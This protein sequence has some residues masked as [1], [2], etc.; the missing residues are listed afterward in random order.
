MKFGG[1]LTT[2]KPS[3]NAFHGNPGTT[4]FQFIGV[5][6]RISSLLFVPP[7]LL[8]R[9]STPPPSPLSFYLVLLNP[10]RSTWI[11]AAAFKTQEG[12]INTTIQK[13]MKI[14]EN[15]ALWILVTSKRLKSYK[16]LRMMEKAQMSERILDSFKIS[17][18]F[19]TVINETKR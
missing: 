3:N 14:L 9:S 12:G 15:I 18:I 19:T 17:L 11:K 8:L 4:A 2:V 16:N 13:T 5:I 1:N 7:P 6:H 10:Q